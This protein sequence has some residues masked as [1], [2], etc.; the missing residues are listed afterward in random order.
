MKRICVCVCV[1]QWRGRRCV[2][3][4][5]RISGS[6]SSTCW[7]G[8]VVDKHTLLERCLLCHQHEG[9]KHSLIFGNN[10]EQGHVAKI[11]SKIAKMQEEGNE[12][13]KLILVLVT[14]LMVKCPFTDFWDSFPENDTWYWNKYFL[15]KFNVL[16][17]SKLAENGQTSLQK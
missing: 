1:T 10:D 8:I 3:D 6:S 14:S 15:I 7:W 5:F 13:E 2:E 12:I 4:K 9:A 11:K 17:I 16:S